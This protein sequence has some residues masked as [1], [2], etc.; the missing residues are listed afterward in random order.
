MVRLKK[1]GVTSIFWARLQN[2]YKLYIF[3]AY[4]SIFL[5]VK[6]TYRSYNLTGILFP[7]YT[8]FRKNTTVFVTKIDFFDH[9]YD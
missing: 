5:K 1:G 3:A 2:N 6:G 8:I 4:F 9:N 7:L